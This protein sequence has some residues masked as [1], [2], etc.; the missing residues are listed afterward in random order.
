MFLDAA[1][2][3][4]RRLRLAGTL[5]AL[6]GT[7]AFSAC[8]PRRQSACGDENHGPQCA[9]ESGP[10]GLWGIRF[11]DSLDSK[12]RERAERLAGDPCAVPSYKELR[13]ARALARMEADIANRDGYVR[14]MPDGSASNP[15]N[16]RFAA[17]PGALALEFTASEALN[18]VDGQ[19]HALTLVIYQLSDRVALDGLLAT[20]EGVAKLLAGERFDE[21]VKSARQLCIQPGMTN[22]LSMERAE[23]ARHVALVAGYHHPAQPSDYVRVFSYGIGQISVK[24]ATFTSRNRLRFRPLPLNLRAELGDEGMTAW[25]TTKIFHNMHDAV[26]LR[27]DPY[28][29][30]IEAA[31]MAVLAP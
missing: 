28:Y 3:Q 4:Q 8:S 6:A 15:D 10:R 16:V 24:G 22:R 11:D 25:E 9:G 20:R 14:V 21:S 30:E 29:A 5:L 23:G 27:S 1:T 19:P 18:M 31:D 26:K 7:L 2:I 13:E 17:V 12:R